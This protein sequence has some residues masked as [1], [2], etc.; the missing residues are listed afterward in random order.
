M[1]RMV[2]SKYS[3][4]RAKRFCIRTDIMV[5]EAGEKK[6]Y[7]H[8]LTPEGRAHIAQIAASYQNLREAYRMSGI[9]FCPCFANRAGN[10]ADYVSVPFLT[11]V[12]LQ[13][14]IKRLA[15]MGDDE[16]IGRIFGE[17][18]RRIREDGGEEPFVVTEEF[19]SVFG[20]LSE[21]EQT[22]L[23]GA[24]KNAN[25]SAKVSDVDMILSNLFVDSEQ[26]DVAAADWQVIDYEWTFHFPIPKGFLIYRG[27]YFAYY[28]VLYH[29]NWGLKRLLELA[30]IAKEEAMVYRRMEEQFQRYLAEGALPIR[31]M[32]RVFGAKVV[33]LEELLDAQGS[34]GTDSGKSRMKADW[35][36]VRKIE[37]HIDRNEY[38]EERYICSGWAFAV[39][40]DGRYLPVN[41]QVS[42][43]KG[44]PVEAEIRRRERKDVAAMLGAG[45]PN[46]LRLG[47]DCV[48]TASSNETWKVYFS[49]GR[50]NAFV[51]AEM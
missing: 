45:S 29:T 16:N 2:Y 3:N 49:L 8:A 24:G 31:S 11:G 25:V 36:L 40:W 47:F 17:Y 28:Q 26:T 23:A 19:E 10:E 33:T 5:D 48:W 22:I 13:D 46:C 12:T 44:R 35:L 7:K 9:T 42:D 51:V 18:I 38:Q 21:E 30:D 14:V 27:L 39:T 50:K 34:D 1:E 37:Y 32:Q 4:E 15:D 41:I 20:M 43:D 6:V